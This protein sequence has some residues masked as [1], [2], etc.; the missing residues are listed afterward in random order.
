[1]MEEH[2]FKLIIQDDSIR[3]IEANRPTE[4]EFCAPGI[5][6][7]E[8]IS[9]LVTEAIQRRFEE[10]VSEYIENKKGKGS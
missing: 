4:I 7:S 1:M 6:E 10:I 8:F 3:I 9:G 2:H 5:L